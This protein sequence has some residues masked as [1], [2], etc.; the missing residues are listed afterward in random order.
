MRYLFEDFALDADKRE[1]HK[2][3]NAVSLTPQA[4]DLLLHLIRNRDRVVS[5]DDLIADVWS[6]RIV[7]E[8][9]LTSRINAV[10]RAVGDSGQKQ[11]LVRT[12]AR[13]GLRFVA[14]VRESEVAPAREDAK[15]DAYPATSERPSIAV[16]PFQ[17][18]SGDAEQDFFAD[19]VTED[20]IIALS[21]V[22]WFSV[23]ARSSAFAYR[24]SELDAKKVASELGVRYVLLGTLRRADERVRVAAQLV[25]GNSGENVWARSYDHA[26]S[27]IFTVQDELTQTIVGALQ[28]ELSRAER[29][30]ARVKP[31]DNIDAW[32]IYQRG[33][34]HLYRFTRD[35]VAQARKLF[36][37]ALGLDAELGPAYSGI[38]ET[39]HCEVV[40][41]LTDLPAANRDRA[42][43][44]ARKAVELDREDAGAHCTLGRIRYLRGEYAAAISELTTA[45]DL[46]PSLALAH[47]SLGATLVFSGRP[48]EA[49]PHLESAIRL[50]PCDPN[51]GSFLVRIAEAKYRI[52]DDDAAAQYALKA[53]GQPI[54]SWVRYAVLI[55]ALAQLGRVAEA[56]AYLR[57][58]TLVVPEFSIAFIEAKHPFSRDMGT[59]RYYEGLNKAG[60]PAMPRNPSQ[61]PGK[62][63]GGLIE[64]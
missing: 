60:V 64:A 51:L 29:E 43:A 2:A 37:S 16:L 13:K 58:V 46:N 18:I 28:P 25:D 17:N 34:F 54:F 20:I 63:R 14:A 61:T 15:V 24:S 49:F 23:I 27:G 31:H 41:G 38:A 36:E 53:L 21:R 5:K 47:Y 33:M 3:G 50:S 11:R 30:R 19:G 22:R 12:F 52:G 32:T 45:L 8:S 62:A 48:D 9:T 10:R 55:A 4:F 6:G 42:L 7:S 59:D 56:Q 35:D 26:L 40:Y 44:P 57:E 39:Y 1:L